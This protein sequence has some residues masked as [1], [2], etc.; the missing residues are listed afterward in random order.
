MKAV[1]AAAPPVARESASQRQA[2]AGGRGRMAIDREAATAVVQAHQRTVFGFL[3]ARLR[4]A[5]TAEDLCQEV[6]LRYLTGRQMPADRPGEQAAWLVGIA[7]NVLREHVRRC[8][9]RKE[10]SWTALCLDIDSGTAD[11][12]TADED[13][14][15]R[16]PACLGGLGQTARSALDMHYGESLRLAEIAGRFGRSEGAVKLLLFRARQAVRRCLERAAAPEGARG[17][18]NV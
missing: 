13:V 16:L 8:V 15:A 4:D 9:R 11:E 14:L 12:G 3:R 5:G 10:V 7:R 1:D 17:A 6:F 18:D 2:R